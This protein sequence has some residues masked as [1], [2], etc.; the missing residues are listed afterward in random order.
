VSAD[1]SA[2]TGYSLDSVGTQAFHWSQAS[3]IVGLPPLS[4]GYDRGQGTSLSADGSAV[5]GYCYSIPTSAPQQACR[6]TFDGLQWTAQGLGDL[7]G[8]GFFSEAD[9]VSPDGSIIVGGSETANG[10]EAFVW[11]SVNGMR[12][13][14]DYLAANGVSVPGGWMLRFANSVTV[15]AGTVTMVGWGINPLGQQ[16]AWIEVVQP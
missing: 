8:G 4:G 12:R 13:V 9:G 5:A 7:H 10:N 11:D 2:A 16:E 14:L 1:G 6:W 15:N 3:D